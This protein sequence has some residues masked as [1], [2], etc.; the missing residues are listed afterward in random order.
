M[1]CILPLHHMIKH[2]FDVI[3]TTA[4]FAVHCHSPVSLT[5]YLGKA[6]WLI[7]NDN[8]QNDPCVSKMFC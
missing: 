1:N 2:V 4:C 7:I 6:G 3:N 5:T 8:H